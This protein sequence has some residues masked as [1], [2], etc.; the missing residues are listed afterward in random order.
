MEFLCETIGLFVALYF[1][2]KIDNSIAQDRAECMEIKERILRKLNNL[3][4]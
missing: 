4:F 1:A 3:E 2:G